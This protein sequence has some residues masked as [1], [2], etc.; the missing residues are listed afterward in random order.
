MVQGF[1]LTRAGSI[2]CIFVRTSVAISGT[3]AAS[4]LHGT[5]FV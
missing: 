4:I 2:F 5:V 3:A 1:R